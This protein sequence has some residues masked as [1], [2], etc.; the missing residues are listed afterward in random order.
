MNGEFS[1][2]VV[3]VTGALGALGSVIVKRFADEG[4]VVYACFRGDLSRFEQEKSIFGDGLVFPCSFDVRSAD[5]CS[6]AIS[7][8]VDTH[9][10][11]DIL[12][13]N[14]AV[15][16]PDPFM[17]TDNETWDTILS[18]NLD[19]VRHLCVAA[20]KPMMIQRSGVI[21]NISSVLAHTLG[22]G[23]S[24]YAASKAA[25]DRFTEVTS[26]ELGKRGIRVNAVAPG[27]L[28]SGMGDAMMSQ[29][30]KISLDRT[31]LG[32][33]GTPDEVANAVLFLSSEKASYITGHI[34]T[35]DGGL[36][37]G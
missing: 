13:N 10:K 35:V 27:L 1:E 31:P 18:T 16:K 37:C 21:I 2:K 22:R 4:A 9:K 24:A 6:V 36:R 26:V 15:N 11:I 7:K 28:Q 33:K 34:L 23:S 5:Q 12:I 19:A 32:R 14:A 20:A 3:V 17:V 25:L 30:E 29:A 8:I